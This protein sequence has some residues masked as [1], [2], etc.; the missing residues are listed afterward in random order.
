MTEGEYIVEAFRKAFGNDRSKRICLYGTGRYTKLLLEELN[1]FNFVGV[2]DFSYEKKNWEGYQVLS[3]ADVEEKADCIV[4]IVNSR[5]ISFVYKKIKNLSEKVKIY[6]IEKQDFRK[7]EQFRE[8]ASIEQ[9]LQG[10]KQYIISEEDK[11][12]LERFQRK[13]K[14]DGGT[15]IQDIYSFIIIFIAPWMLSYFAW[16]LNRIRESDAEIVLMSSRDGYLFYRLF[17]LLPDDDCCP[18]PSIKYFY[19]SR[20]CLSVASIKNEQDI[21]EIVRD[22]YV[23]NKRSFL[24][25]RFGV[26]VLLKEEELL[27]SNED[28][29]LRYKDKILENAREERECLEKYLQKEQID[30]NKNILLFDFIGRGTVQYFLEKIMGKPL[31]CLY[32]WKILEEQIVKLKP[33]GKAITYSG[34]SGLYRAKLFTQRNLWFEAIVTASHGMVD[35]LGKDGEPVFRE[36]KGID[37]TYFDEVERAC[38]DYYNEMWGKSLPEELNLQLVDQMAELIRYNCIYVDEKVKKCLVAANPFL[39]DCFYAEE[40]I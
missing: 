2:A 39:G 22:E 21:K 4:L 31:S 36:E 33:T 19:T 5:N 28:L 16:T 12:T 26:K 20:R 1:D 27:L 34:E 29:A 14:Y 40:Y 13:V 17:Q 35:R 10:L 32:Y 25:D 6:T 30:K 24:E 7:K 15:G 9:A 37:K 8:Q 18:L 11:R 38:V 3:K 23:G